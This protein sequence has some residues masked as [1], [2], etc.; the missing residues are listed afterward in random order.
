MSP[1]SM[2]LS[3]STGTLFCG[4]LIWSA[5]TYLCKFGAHTFLPIASSRAVCTGGPSE[6]QRG[7]SGARVGEVLG[8]IFGAVLIVILI[9][10]LVTFQF[11]KEKLQFLKISYISFELCPSDNQNVHKFFLGYKVLILKKRSWAWRH[12]LLQYPAVGYLIP[13]RELTKLYRY[14]YPVYTV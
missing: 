13:E 1:Q 14:Q 5:S 8:E 2:V 9:I 10:N 7:L 12:T 11:S 6:P 4:P 3:S